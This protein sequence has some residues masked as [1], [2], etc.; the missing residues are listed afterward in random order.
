MRLEHF[1]K[2]SCKLCFFVV[3]LFLLS[4]EAFASDGPAYAQFFSLNTQLPGSKGQKAVFDHTQVRSDIGLDASRTQ[5][6]IKQA[7]TYFIMVSGQVG[8]TG[9]K[10]N[11]NV[12]MYL[13]R[14]GKAVSNS[15]S[16]QTVTDPVSV[17]ITGTQVILHL[18]QDDKISVGIKADIPTLGLIPTP[19]KTNEPAVPSIKLTIYKLDK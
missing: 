10:L 16:S 17:S 6:I 12:Y 19:A 8:S 4:V 18:A 13:I 11:G 2:A 15:G 7:G 5:A 9:L 3:S 1:T 14:N